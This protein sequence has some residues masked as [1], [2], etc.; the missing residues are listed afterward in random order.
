[1]L[2]YSN[3]SNRASSRSKLFARLASILACVLVTVCPNGWAASDNATI[4]VPGTGTES[5]FHPRTG[6]FLYS[7]KWEATSAAE[8]I[9]T[10]SK[11]GDYYRIVA[12]STVTK[13]VDFI[14]RLRYRGEGTITRDDFAP[15]RTVLTEQKGSEK[16]TTR[17]VYRDDGEI[18]TKVTRQKKKESPE[19]TVKQFRPEREVL[20][21][22]S[23][24]F[25]SR[26]IDW[27]VGLSEEFEVFT[28]RKSYIVT[29]NCLEKTQFKVNDTE[30]D[31]WVIAPAAI[32][33]NK[34]DQKPRLTSTRIYLSADESKDILRIKT[35]TGFGTV[36]AI[37][38]DFV[39]F[40]GPEY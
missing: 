33:P 28:G 18:E 3:I 7:V 21:I 12:D 8:I 27:N 20:D 37:L 35:R 34:P 11:Q 36:E 4:N 6:T 10:V 30:I 1:M 22:F 16:K 24:V 38:T 13:A 19:T 23:A 9:L 14:Y 40:L 39:P 25:L 26:S 5:K 2:V 15:V 29:L 31:A 32:D 17:I